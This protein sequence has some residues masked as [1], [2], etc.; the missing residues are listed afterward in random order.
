M[1]QQQ[2]RVIL[3]LYV[4]NVMEVATKRKVFKVMEDICFI[5]IVLVRNDVFQIVILD[6][7][8]AAQ[9]AFPHLVNARF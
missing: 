1:V 9:F 5:E 3:A 6:A 7:L 4:G 8:A 2:I